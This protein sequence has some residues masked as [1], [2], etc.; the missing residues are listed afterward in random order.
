MPI[1]NKFRSQCIDELDN[2]FLLKRK[3]DDSCSK[4]ILYYLFA[5]DLAKQ[6]P[7]NSKNEDCIQEISKTVSMLV[8]SKK[9]DTKIINTIVNN[10][11]LYIKSKTG[12]DY[13]KL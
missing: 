4:A 2:S 5:R 10:G 3:V 13:R 9:S 11:Y 1:Y 8:G 6:C 12:I 7:A